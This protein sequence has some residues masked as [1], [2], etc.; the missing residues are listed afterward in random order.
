[1]GSLIKVV[2]PQVAESVIM[3][4]LEVLFM[5]N[6]FCSLPPYFRLFWESMFSRTV[7]C[8]VF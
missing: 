6:R 5:S 1:M 7:L 3:S 4:L 8:F 2:F